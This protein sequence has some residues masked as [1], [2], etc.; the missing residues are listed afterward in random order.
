MPAPREV[1]WAGIGCQL[2]LASHLS[3]PRRSRQAAEGPAQP[4]SRG[5]PR[6]RSSSLM[7][8]GGSGDANLA[9]PPEDDV[10]TEDML[11]RVRTMLKWRVAASGPKAKGKKKSDVMTE[12]F[13]A[14][15]LKYDKDGVG[16]LAF[17]DIRRMCRTDLR[18][19]D[20]LVSDENLRELFSAID[21]D[22]GGKVEFSE[23]LEFVNLPGKGPKA[24]VDDIVQEVARTVRLALRRNKIYIGDLEQ[25]FSNYDDGGDSAPTGELGPEEMRNFFRRVLRLTRHECSDKNLNTAFKAMDD[26]GSGTMSADEFMDF[27]KFCN[28][29]V[30][31]KEV[32]T[33]VHGLLGGTRDFLDKKLPRHRPGTQPDMPLAHV[34]FCLNGRDLPPASRFASSQDRSA[35]MR[36]TRNHS[37]TQSSSRSSMSKTEGSE[38]GSVVSLPP[39]KRATSMPSMLPT[40]SGSP[41]GGYKT[42][43]GAEALNRVEQ[44]LWECGMDVRGHY[45][46][47]R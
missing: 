28:A 11:C 5:G 47:L 26:D 25:K 40:G 29:G 34:P 6:L 31:K 37:R 18:I 17:E 36:V 2:L 35:H 30:Q 8:S 23:F 45:H 46:R 10:D 9:P 14:L 21:E 15:F 39:M 33:K 41:S 24:T 1:W 19:A 27:I 43:K 12:R 44:R 3:A 16:A 22:G 4:P 7:L 20:R 38:S 42:I 13:K 32:P